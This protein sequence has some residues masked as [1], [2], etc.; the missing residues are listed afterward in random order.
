MKY[1]FTGEPAHQLMAGMGANALKPQCTSTRWW[2]GSARPFG[3]RPRSG[4][5]PEGIAPTWC[6]NGRWW[7]TSIRYPDGVYLE[8]MTRMIDAAAE[9]AAR[10]GREGGD[11]PLRRIPRRH[12]LGTL[13]EVMFAYAKK[14][15]PPTSMPSQE[16]SPPRYEE[17][18]RMSS[19]DARRRRRRLQL[20]RVYRT[21]EMAVDAPHS[22]VGHRGLPDRRPGHGGD[23]PVSTT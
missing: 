9:G 19:S 3:R 13:E 2:T 23:L 18:G 8:H 17:T 21:K 7:T 20:A 5:I 4:V 12:R 22:P 14:L 6:R 15:A 10:D 1:V 11:R 16:A